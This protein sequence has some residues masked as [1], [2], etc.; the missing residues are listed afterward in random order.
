MV[1]DTVSR[2]RSSWRTGFLAASVVISLTILYSLPGAS[3]VEIVVDDDPGWWAQFNTIQDAL[4]A[5]S[6]GDTIRVYKGNYSESVSVFTQVDI[7]GNGTDV[8]LLNSSSPTDEFMINAD[9]VTVSQMDIMT[10]RLTVQGTECRLSNLTVSGGIDV[11]GDDNEIQNLSVNGSIGL[12]LSDR[13]VIADTTIKNGMNSLFLGSSDRNVIH[14]VTVH[15]SHY[16]GINLSFS[17]NNEFTDCTLTNGTMQG[18]EAWESHNN[19]FD[20]IEVSEFG[21]TGIQFAVGHG[22][23]L[24]NS[25]VHNNDLS[26]IVLGRNSLNN[27]TNNL[28]HSNGEYGI[29]VSAYG[30]SVDNWI[31]R[32]RFIDNGDH[33]SQGFDNTGRNH[34]SYGNVGN[35][36]SDYVGNDTNHDGFGDAPYLI[37]GGDSADDAPVLDWIRIRNEVPRI[38]RVDSPRKAIVDEEVHFNATT[39]DDGVITHTW[40]SDRDGILHSGVD[41]NFSTD[42]LSVGEHNIT[43]DIEDDNGTI[44]VSSTIT[45][46]I[47]VRPEVSIAGPIDGTT[48]SGWIW[49]NGTAED[50]DGELIIVQ[51]RIDGEQWLG[52]NGTEIWSLAYD[53][54]NLTNG[55]HNITVRVRDEHHFSFYENIT[56]IVDNSIDPAP[57]DPAEPF[58][59]EEEQLIVAGIVAGGF[60]AFAATGIGFYSLFGLLFPLYTKLKEETVADQKTR[61][62]IIEY[63][64]HNP[65][66]HFS[67]IKKDLEMPNGSAGYHLRVLEASGFLRAR[68]DGFYKRFYPH[69]YRIP[70]FVLDE[71]EQR[72]VAFVQAE[73]GIAQKDLATKIGLSPSTVSHH[74]K[75]LKRKNVVNASRGE[76]INLTDDYRAVLE[77]EAAAAEIEVVEPE[78][79]AE[80]N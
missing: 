7:E 12:T 37:D 57:K 77:T 29:S 26:G 56:I 13:N 49:F 3:S 2:S 28:V 38:L 52:T 68:S 48:V 61:G 60:V 9:F 39:R 22:N 40:T 32:N 18:I 75:R 33:S 17:S 19:I 72:I 53:T 69:G 78:I 6:D 20:N 62:R 1:D 74:I 71:T 55:V 41:A 10:Y 76:G 23:I 79:V 36:W 50:E 5:S 45:I 4:N 21:E 46:L 14:N 16:I 30:P 25:N 54:W 58:L 66:A 43:L 51:I 27:I 34:W 47:N 63:I 42:G 8:S 35:E 80:N 67:M 24:M 31:F 44:G 59:S 64:R 70:E 65:G 15:D 73:P 11:L